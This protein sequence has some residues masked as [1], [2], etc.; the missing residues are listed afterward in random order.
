MREMSV[1]VFDDCIFSKDLKAEC[2]RQGLVSTR[3]LEDGLRGKDDCI[4]LPAI[5]DRGSILVTVDRAMPEENAEFLSKDHPGLLVVASEER[6][7][8]MTGR[9]ARAIFHRL[10]SV[11]PNWHSVAIRNS[12]VRATQRTVF[13]YH[14]DG[15]PMQYDWH[16][17]LD[18]P[19]MPAALLAILER[20]ATRPWAGSLP[21]G[22]V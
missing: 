14:A 15:G 16:W 17:S 2:D 8:T 18:D 20:N 13:V 21:G 7:R 4:V 1:F 5:V 22:A 10:K 19:T 12:I 3:R 11:L 9:L 6:T